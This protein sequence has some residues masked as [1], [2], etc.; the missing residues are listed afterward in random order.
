MPAQLPTLIPLPTKF[1]LVK[2]EDIDDPFFLQ[3]RVETRMITLLQ[4]MTN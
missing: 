3:L 4:P 1:I 2:F